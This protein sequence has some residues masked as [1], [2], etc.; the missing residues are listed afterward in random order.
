M[1]ILGN[2]FLQTVPVTTQSVNGDSSTV[3][4]V[5]SVGQNA[6]V[7]PNNT[8][9]IEELQNTVQT[10]KEQIE[11]QQTILW[12][13][14]GLFVLYIIYTFISSRRNQQEQQTTDDTQDDRLATLEKKLEIKINRANSALE[15]KMKGMVDD[16]KEQATIKAQS[17]PHHAQGYSELVREWKESHGRIAQEQ[18][19][20]IPY[21]PA[22]KNNIKYF[23]PQESGGQLSVKERNLKD[24]GSRSWFVM[25]INGDMATYDINKQVAEDILA[26]Q[27][28]LRICANEFEPNASARD[29]KTI[30]K[31]TLRKEGQSW[32]VTEKITI[33]LV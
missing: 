29:I 19:R 4:T 26:D 1:S 30:K 33:E 21:S 22:P 20:D 8:V 15:Q 14:I 6:S 11:T 17:T 2:I 23:T 32:I 13:L 31:G 7:V 24:D 5:D 12:V 9:G 27:S 3:E 10:L 28:V 18:K 16:V 25:A